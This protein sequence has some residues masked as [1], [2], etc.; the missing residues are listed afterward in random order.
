MRRGELTPDE[1]LHRARDLAVCARVRAP[2][3]EDRRQLPESTLA[4]LL[5]SGL[6]GL[7]T[8]RRWGGSE[9]PPRVWVDVIAE[10]SAA[11][12]STGWVYG[13]LLGHMWLVS[14][15][16]YATQE[17]IFGTPGSLV[18]SLVRLGGAAPRRVSG[19]Y[20]WRGAAGAF[21]SGVDYAQWVV[22]GGTFETADGATESRWFLIPRSDIEIVD[23][24]FTSG[25]RG[26]GSKSI[27]VADAF[28]PEHRSIDMRELDSGTAPG[29][30]LNPGALYRLPGSTWAFVLAATP[31]GVARGA[32][33]SVRTHLGARLDGLD[34][35]RVAEQSAVIGRFARAA[36]DVDVAGLLL[37]DRAERLMASA[38]QPY[39]S[40]D[41]LVHRRDMAYAVQ[42]ARHAVNELME[43]SG[44]SGI[45]DTTTIQRQWRDANAAAAHFGL[46][47]E[48]A[49][50][51]YG[52]GLLGLP[53]SKTGR[54]GQ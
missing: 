52:R 31:I 53:A 4:E 16:P 13:V 49:A 15:F 37:T 17:E 35:E 23:D 19:G 21:C 3:A 43:L 27:R 14:Q 47:W 34:P 39:T 10:L 5:D 46:A 20:R 44:G 1:A 42:Q 6:F 11:C 36:T 38:E 24:W 51:A 48:P 2:Q 32:L 50:V 22:A 40:L 28:I 9:L 29:R 41:R 8:P 45:Y 30:A 26:T 33:E 7:A 18:A 12:G 54:V 25:L